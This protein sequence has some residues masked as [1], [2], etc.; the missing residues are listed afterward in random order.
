[1]GMLISETGGVCGGMTTEGGGPI[2][3]K[4]EAGLLV[5]AVAII[6]VSYFSIHGLLVPTGMVTLSP[7]DIDSCGELA[8]ENGVYTLTANVT[9]S[10]T[11]FTINANNV[12]LNCNGNSITGDGPGYGIDNTLGYN[13]TTVENCIITNFEIGIDFDNGSSY[14]TIE[15]NVVYLNGHGINLAYTGN[16][17]IIANHNVIA[18]NTANSNVGYGIIVYRNSYN[19]VANNIAN[20]NGN[21]GIMIDTIADN[22][23][24]SNNTA[25]SNGNYGIDLFTN[26]NNIFTYNT[27][28]SNDNKGIHIFG[29]SYNTFA[30]NTVN[31][32]SNFGVSIDSSSNNTFYNN[33][34][35]NAN[36]LELDGS[37][38]YWNITN[39]TGPNI[40][41]GQDIGGNFWMH[42][43]S[44]DFSENSAT[45]TDGDGDGICDSQY[46]FDSNNTDE[47]PLAVL[48]HLGC[49]NLNSADTVY[50]MTWRV[51]A[52]DTCFAINANN[53]TLDCKGNTI[54]YSQVN[55]GRGVAI[56]G[57]NHTTI[58][59]CIITE[60]AFSGESQGIV[61]SGDSETFTN[62]TITTYGPGAHCIHGTF[63]NSIISINNL[64]PTDNAGIFLFAVSSNNYVVGN[65]INTNGSGI[66]LDITGG[67]ITNNTFMG[68]IIVNTRDYADSIGT[69][70][71]NLDSHNNFTSNIITI[72]GTSSYGINAYGLNGSLITGN[73]ITIYGANSCGISSAW[74]NSI[75][76]NNITAFADN[77]VSITISNAYS[78]NISRNIIIT[79]GTN[80]QG[81]NAN[82]LNDSFITNNNIMAIADSSNG[83][84]IYSSFN[85]D[86]TGNNVTVGGSD[87]NGIYYVVSSGGRI[88]GN[89]IT[90]TGF[91]NPGINVWGSS[92]SNVTNN[93]VLTEN[94]SGSTA[95]QADSNSNHIRV[96]DNT[97]TAIGP[98][99]ILALYNGFEYTAENNTISVVGPSSHGIA[100]SNSQ[101]VS[102]LSNNIT[103]NASACGSNG[104]ALFS[105]VNSI[106]T[107]NIQTGEACEYGSGIALSDSNS[108]TISDN[109]FSA[110]TNGNGIQLR[111]SS[112]NV[113]NNNI[114]FA[115]GE[116]SWG[117]RILTGSNE[118]LAY[119][120]INSTENNSFG[121]EL[122]AISDSRITN[123]NIT[124]TGDNTVGPYGAIDFVGTN[125]LFSENILEVYG[126]GAN[127][128]VIEHESANNIFFGNIV[129]A[130]GYAAPGFVGWIADSTFDSNI[131][132][133]YEDYAT[134]MAFYS[135]SNNDT[136]VNNT[137][138]TNGPG[139]DGIVLQSGTMNINLTGNNITTTADGSNGIKLMGYY[140][141]LT[142]NTIT[143]NGSNS[144][145]IYAQSG[146]GNI[147]TYNNISTSGE[148]D[149]GISL[150]IGSDDILSYNS[151][152]STGDYSFGIYL[153]EI[154]DSNILDNNITTMGIS[155]GPHGGID[156]EA[157]TNNTF[158][159]NIVEVYGE[160][161]NCMLI[162]TLH[163]NGS[164]FVEN[165]LTTHGGWGPGIV[166]WAL[167]NI[168]DG[169]IVTTTEDGANGFQ[170]Y[171]GSS[172]NNITGNDIIATGSNSNGIT[173]QGTNNFGRVAADNEI[174]T[175]GWT[176]AQNA[177][178]WEDDTYATAAPDQNSDITSLFKN[179]GFDYPIQAGEHINSVTINPRYYVDTS[180]S[181]AELRVQVTVSGENCPE[182]IDSSQPLENTDVYLDVTSCREWTLDDLLDAN[183]SVK[184]GAYRGDSVTPVTF[185]L[186]SVRVNVNYGLTTG[187]NII[188]NNITAN[189]NGIQLDSSNGNTLA[190]NNASS[191]G[192]DGIWLSSSSDNN[193]SDNTVNSNGNHG[194]NLLSG[195]SGN[196]I[197]NNIVSSNSNE[198]IYI[199]QSSNNNI[200]ANNTITLNNEGIRIDASSDNTIYNNFFNNSQNVISD[201]SPNFW[202]TTKIP[203]TNIINGTWIGGNFW[204][205]PFG[206]GFSEN[207]FSCID[208]D[209]NGICDSSYPLGE[210][211]ADYLPLAAQVRSSGSCGLLAQP[212]AVYTLTANVTGT[213]TC[214]TVAAD[215][216]TLDCNGSSITGDGTGYG[217]DNTLGYNHTTV[218][219]CTINGFEVGIISDSSFNARSNIADNNIS[220]VNSIIIYGDSG[221]II[222]G[223]IL[224]P[225]GSGGYDLDSPRGI[226]I[227]LGSGSNDSIIANNTFTTVS[228]MG[229]WSDNGAGITI[230]GNNFSVTGVNY[231]RAVGGMLSNSKISRNIITTFGS[232]LLHG[233]WFDGSNNTIADNVIFSTSTNGRGIQIDSGSFNRIDNDTISGGRHGILIN[234]A[235][236]TSITNSRIYDNARYGIYAYPARGLVLTNN[237]IRNNSWVGVIL[238]GEYVFGPWILLHNNIT[239]NA[240]GIDI[241]YMNYAAPSVT[242]HSGNH[243]WETGLLTGQSTKLAHTFNL[244]NA[245]TA[246]LTFW[247]TYDTEE[248]YDGG[249]VEVNNGSGWTQITP[250]EGYSASQI[251]D[252]TCMFDPNC[253]MV[254]AYTGSSDWEPATFNLTAY[255]GQTIQLRFD[256]GTDS[257][258]EFPGWFIDD[259]NVTKDG[260]EVF[261]DDVEHGTNNWTVDSNDAVGWAIDGAVNIDTNPVIK[262]NSIYDNLQWNLFN[263][264]ENISAKRNWWNSLDCASIDANISDDEEGSGGAVDFDPFL[265]SPDPAGPTDT[266]A[267][268]P[269]AG[270]E[271]IENVEVVTTAVENGTEVNLT[272]VINE[273]AGVTVPIVVSFVIPTGETIDMAP[274]KITAVEGLTIIRNLTL[275]AGVTKSAQVVMPSGKSAV[276]VDDTDGASLSAN[277]NAAGEVAVP[278]PGSASGFTCTIIN[279]T[280]FAVSGLTHSAIGSYTPAVP[281]GTTSNVCT[282]ETLSCT[283]WN[284]CS[285][286][287]VQQR[288][289]AI[290]NSTCDRTSVIQTQSCTYVPAVQPPAVQPP[291]EQ[292]VAPPVTPAPIPTATVCG[293]RMCEAGEDATNCP[294][295]CA[296][297][298]WFFFPGAGDVVAWVL[299]I[300]TAI[301]LIA[302]IFIFSGRYAKH[303]THFHRWWG[304]PHRKP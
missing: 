100:T 201:G 281:S 111:L 258:L 141:N 86:L 134:G 287:S 3:N 130:H 191:N 16:N 51:F 118:T 5:L 222:S 230:T 292:P 229:I 282:P 10:G 123:N 37:P 154:S 273:T 122:N 39:T 42:P 205:N 180:E 190:D 160:N 91:N 94:S 140:N 209:G 178:G 194:I 125:D 101:N 255:A 89:N 103:L 135:G 143:T 69:V 6:A 64:N 26:S 290:R 81:I 246:E 108:S 299:G 268:P 267:P 104:I 233:I 187:N 20:S 78:Q 263:N 90:T 250:N 79:N 65:T 200:I 70:G 167:G 214:F 30:N 298:P 46:G 136:V 210:N 128:I 238:G 66:S 17:D 195:S 297:V 211:N 304:R 156:F 105:T 106:I 184:V 27:V 119:N 146:S 41:G 219:N 285:S 32:N 193:I 77:S 25:N 242:P 239:G 54:I 276:C 202:N 107:G 300:V 266:C 252:W 93:N 109:E 199:V 11:C 1:M 203:G 61:G 52:D 269:V 295:D 278:C 56:N 115:S 183:F 75:I 212:D 38:N 235:K 226:G 177:I 48:P 208:S 129:T 82:G 117:M 220:S 207:A 29:S 256:Y 206:T 288:T 279:A 241:T 249:I 217:V 234:N 53:V 150:Y 182:V 245:L 215:N 147:L 223:N 73:N 138:T 102:L 31:S 43:D 149:S 92:Y 83:I 49:S 155:G 8:D 163:G 186:D 253:G 60:G 228:N 40:V 248:G 227:D 116:N 159:G 144:N 24:V 232:F 23:I 74:P 257:G 98:S 124:T 58:K 262:N 277:C 240:V 152:N 12:T 196:T 181:I 231:N 192:N 271:E 97:L 4:A 62:N 294:R 169:N 96:A 114:I 127:G 113:C 21:S 179:Y 131:I 59:N 99:T 175:V 85:N 112:D 170:F 110:G 68:N 76:D 291:I 275:P 198:G 265:L 259:I 174:V 254:D 221:S 133:V 251:N 50:N 137:I 28:S 171:P 95:I 33:L 71:T 274:V 67:P 272:S 157:G 9:N 225:T 63:T 18:N 237:S 22:N 236:N 19:I 260:A 44:E 34:F 164:R 243:V 13:Y 289:C 165:I 173:I 142:G 15:N 224:T 57:Y 14:G 55:S 264:N 197:A 261:F 216:V 166:G 283:D 47:L 148:S 7:G 36:N 188:H 121:M 280:L 72:S 87:S 189:R 296:I 126:E 247:H 88:T 153:N 161:A 120:I 286:S 84:F 303:K 158:S 293:N 139:A 2:R 301:I 168:I 35:N 45:C 162:N 302:A 270:A 151:I 145:G 218:K 284:A 176:D 80:S 213:G 244:T 185:Y 132:T 172:N 204:A